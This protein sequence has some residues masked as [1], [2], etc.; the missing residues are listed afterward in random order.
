MR[1]LLFDLWQSRHVFARVRAVALS[2]RSIA[3]PCCRSLGNELYPRAPNAFHVN[4]CIVSDMQLLQ[5]IVALFFL[6]ISS[7]T[8]TGLFHHSS[9]NDQT[10]QGHDARAE[11]AQPSVPVASDTPTRSQD[12]SK[13]PNEA[14]IGKNKGTE[15]LISIPPDFRPGMAPNVFS[16]LGENPAGDTWHS[17]DD[18]VSIGVGWEKDSA[19]S[20][21][22]RLEQTQLIFAER[23]KTRPEMAQVT[24][25]HPQITGATDST[26]LE[27]LLYPE[28]SY[29]IYLFVTGKNGNIYSIFGIS[30]TL[31]S[32]AT[33]EQIVKSF[34][35]R[36]DR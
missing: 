15:Y 13:S 31:T 2:Q 5:H 1:A 10:M 19:E 29:G 4:P 14:P 23:A 6:G 33:V 8:A 28:G 26:R 36:S 17:P 22:R 11:I 3:V 25:S 34:S 20:K 21:I 16:A 18:A 35:L 24:V 12:A 32:R 7:L 27:K 9:V 30:R